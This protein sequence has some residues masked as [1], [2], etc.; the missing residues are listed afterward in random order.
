MRP[1]ARLGREASSIPVFDRGSTP[2][3]Q[4]SGSGRNGRALERLLRELEND[5]RLGLKIRDDTW[6]PASSDRSISEQVQGRIKRLY[7][8]NEPALHKVLHAFREQLAAGP[9]LSSRDRLSL[10]QRL[11]HNETGSPIPRR[12]APGVDIDPH[13]TL[14][15]PLC[16]YR[17]WTNSF[18]VSAR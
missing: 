17:N 8:S 13:K 16:K 1:S 11:L 14:R 15:S 9:L 12:P 7:Y 10:L 5:Y 3:S 2:G 18:F 6:S 4:R